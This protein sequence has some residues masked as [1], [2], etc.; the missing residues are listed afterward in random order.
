MCKMK[1]FKRL[2]TALLAVLLLLSAS[3]PAALAAVQAT[4]ISTTNVY[5]VPSTSAKSIRVPKGLKVSVTAYQGNWARVNYKGHTAYIPLAYL[6]LVNR[7][8]AYTAKS[9]PVYKNPSTS[10]QKL[11][12]LS[13]ATAVYVVGRA[14]N[15]YR[16]QNASGSVTGY[17]PAGNLTSKAKITAAYNAYKK[18]QAASA[19]KS[20]AKAPSKS[21]GKSSTSAADK[22][23]ALAKSLY[24]RPYS[25]SASVASAPNYFN[26]STFVNYVMSKFGISMKTTAAQQANDNRYA[27]ITSLS[28]LRAGDILCFDG[29]GDGEC[30]HTAIY[31]GDGKFAEASRNAGKVH[32]NSFSNYYK[33]HFMWARRPG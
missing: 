23:K 21:S 25:A 11:G 15:F 29:D 24:G 33:E 4:I 31:L 19:A 10:S 22:L 1:S 5:N 9:T 32:E 18:A 17:V 7:L 27:K 14:G 8:T 26:C 3:A 30:D 6:N 20:K 2:L 16:I 12:T 13:I 28:S